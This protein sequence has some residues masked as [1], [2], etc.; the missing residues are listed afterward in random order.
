MY[1]NEKKNI[2]IY[3][4]PLPSRRDNR[5]N[6]A[7]EWIHAAQ[8]EYGFSVLCPLFRSGALYSVTYTCKCILRFVHQQLGCWILNYSNDTYKLQYSVYI[9]RATVYQGNR[10]LSNIEVW[11]ADFFAFV[12]IFLGC[13]MQVWLFQSY[14]LLIP[15][16]TLHE[17]ILWQALLIQL[18]EHDWN[19]LFY[20]CSIMD[21]LFTG[22]EVHIGKNCAQGLE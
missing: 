19:P 4:P 3:T 6:Y 9:S 12:V 22:W 11:E 8:K 16:L 17:F 20:I 10:L 13:Y 2:Y 14:V 5:F 21:M 7:I 15:Y 18:P 1:V